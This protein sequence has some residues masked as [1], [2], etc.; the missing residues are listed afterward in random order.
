MDDSF[1]PIASASAL[2]EALT[3]S[4]NLLTQMNNALATL[5]PMDDSFARMTSALVP[6][7]MIDD[8]LARMINTMA[9]PPVTEG[10]TAAFTQINDSTIAFAQVNNSFNAAI[11][12]VMAAPPVMDSAA[13]V[14][15]QIDDTW[16]AFTRID[17]LAA[18]LTRIDDTAAVLASTASS[19]AVDMLC[20]STDLFAPMSSTLMTKPV[21]PFSITLE[22]LQ[23]QIAADK[24][25][26]SPAQQ[27]Y[28]GL[29]ASIRDFEAN[30]DDDHEI[31]I[32]LDP[33]G[34]NTAIH[35]ESISYA[36]PDFIIFRGITADKDMRQVKLMIHTS[37]LKVML[38]ALEKRPKT[39]RMGFIQSK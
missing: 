30:L 35:V 9:P 28:E 4:S 23:A 12:G 39:Q 17:D 13:A 16:T 14:L 22:S 10:I 1:D 25:R 15:N 11:A 26:R 5:P 24:P 27:A 6:P 18:T 31:G 7:P 34:Q 21:I 33:P 37:Q 38:T 2:N 19:L 29:L 36:D 32:T 3:S 8:L 20:P